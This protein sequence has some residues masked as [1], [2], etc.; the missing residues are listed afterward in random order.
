MKVQV[1]LSGDVIRGYVSFA[2][3]HI[4]NIKLSAWNLLDQYLLDE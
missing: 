2:D 1:C 4:C 3:C